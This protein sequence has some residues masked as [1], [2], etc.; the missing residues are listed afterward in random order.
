MILRFI[1]LLILPVASYYLAQAL[2]SRFNFT[3]RQRNFVFVFLSAVLVTGVLIALGRLPIQFILAPIG[4]AATFMI[5]FLPTLI[6]FLPIWQ[7][8]RNRT[9][10]SIPNSSNSSSKLRTLFLAMELNH[11]TGDMAGEV[12]NG[13]FAGRKLDELDAAQVAELFRE[14]IKDSDSR[15]VLQAYIERMHPEW[16]GNDLYREGAQQDEGADEMSRP[17]A[18]EIL[19]L[20]DDATH[21]EI[22]SAHRALM[23]KMHPDRGG[24]DYLAK[25]INL[26][27]EFLL[28]N[29]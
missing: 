16:E 6:R 18:M 8:F 3:R 28:K 27:K 29:G 11:Q 23:R 2:S 25:K 13:R 17:L 7:M 26:A 15:Q 4:V 5:R 1:A 10:Q 9:T 20:S 14:C 24:S 21:D 12:L 22:V 19:G